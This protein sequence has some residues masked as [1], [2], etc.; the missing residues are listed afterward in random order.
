MSMICVRCS[1]AMRMTEKDTSSGREIREYVC[2]ECG[3]SDWEDNGLALWQVLSDARE[4]DE[5]ERAASAV[6]GRNGAAT[7][8]PPHEA[9][10]TS[11][12]SRLLARLVHRGQES[13]RR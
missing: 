1:A 6:A 4:A 11:V 2:D 8:A 3:Y 13:A 7:D 5:V 10:A 9:T 12:W